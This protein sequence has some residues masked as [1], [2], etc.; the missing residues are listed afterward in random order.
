MQACG[1]FAVLGSVKTPIW[2]KAQAY[3]SGRYLDSVYG[4]ALR[5]F[6]DM[7]AAEGQQSHEPEHAAR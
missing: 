3:D 6:V 1:P 5:K 7:M 2:G 4:P